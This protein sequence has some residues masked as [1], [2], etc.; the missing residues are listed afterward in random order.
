VDRRWERSGWWWARV[1]VAGLLLG[2][3]WLRKN[4]HI[5]FPGYWNF[6]IFILSWFSKNKWSNQNFREMYIWRRT[7]RR[8]EFLPPWGTTLGETS[9]VGN[10]G[11]W[12]QV[13]DA[14]GH[15]GRI[16]TAAAHGRITSLEKGLSP[17]RR[18]PHSSLTP[19]SKPSAF[20]PS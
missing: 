1:A 20:N 3:R 4:L 8:Q 10:T 14:A 7:P 19:P 9:T 18:P 11:R 13:P 5:G 6:F 15:G 2:Y 16:P 17:C 12:G